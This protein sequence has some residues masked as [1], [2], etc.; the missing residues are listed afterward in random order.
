MA[1][2]LQYLWV[3]TQLSPRQRLGSLVYI[4]IVLWCASLGMLRDSLI[5]GYKVIQDFFEGRTFS[6][7][8]VKRLIF[9]SFFF[10]VFFLAV[11]LFF[12]F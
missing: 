5:F 1:R 10:F 2:F 12:I 6:S 7:V 8:R 4:F 11:A 9:L 3:L